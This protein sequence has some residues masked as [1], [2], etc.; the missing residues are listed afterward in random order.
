M[1]DLPFAGFAAKGCR[2]AQ[3]EARDIRHVS[4]SRLP[5]LGAEHGHQ[6]GALVH[7]NGAEVSDVSV[8][9]SRRGEVES[10]RHFVPALD[11]RSEGI[12][13]G[14]IGGTRVE[15]FHAFGITARELASRVLE[16]LDLL[17][18]FP[19]HATNGCMAP[20]VETSLRLKLDHG[21][22]SL[23]MGKFEIGLTRGL[24]LCRKVRVLKTGKS[25][26]D[27]ALANT[28]IPDAPT[29]ARGQPLAH[30]TPTSRSE[31]TRRSQPAGSA[32]FHA[33]GGAPGT[34]GAS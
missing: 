3:L 23:Q 24:W 17:L 22:K 15:R 4:N 16:A 11:G 28:R 2:D 13:K 29:H 33:K 14:G 31:A 27:G 26:R 20:V 21:M 32:S 30:E 6:I 12:R 9:E 25:V 18:K 7:G 8:G 34:S 1:D 5:P 10:I 19:V